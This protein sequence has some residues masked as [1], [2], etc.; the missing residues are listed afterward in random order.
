M[1]DLNINCLLGKTLVHIIGAEEGKDQITFICSDGSEYVMYHE[2]DCCEEVKI[3]DICGDINNL[4]GHPLTMAEDISNEVDDTALMDNEDIE[5]IVSYTWT[6]YKFATVKGYVTIRWFG[7]SNGYY[8]E[9]V[10]FVKMRDSNAE[11]GNR[12]ITYKS[13][14]DFISHHHR[15]NERYINGIENCDCISGC[16]TLHKKNKSDTSNNDVQCYIQVSCG[17]DCYLRTK[18]STGYF[19]NNR[20]VLHNYDKACKSTDFSS[21]IIQNNETYADIL[22]GILYRSGLFG[23]ILRRVIIFILS[24]TK[25]FDEIGFMYN[26]DGK[27]ILDILFKN[28]YDYD[29]CAKKIKECDQFSLHVVEVQIAESQTLNE[30]TDNIFR[31]IEYGLKGYKKQEFSNQED[32][33]KS[34]L[35]SVHNGIRGGR[36]YYE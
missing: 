27:H 22:D 7:E 15:Y 34:L 32:I 13:I 18:F 24:K 23:E 25:I 1:E 31:T 12:M 35:D 21:Y 17:A 4:I 16:I 8:S 5:Y 10:D 29:I 3:E 28:P 19:Y 9:S 20:Y 14:S 6:W 36:C 33:D 11:V 2:Q 26:I 30:L